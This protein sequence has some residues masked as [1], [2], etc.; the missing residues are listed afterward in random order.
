MLSRK[1][2]KDAHFMLDIGAV[3]KPP[4]T[5]MYHGRRTRIASLRFRVNRF[6]ETDLG[7]M[8]AVGVLSTCVFSGL[9]ISPAMYGIALS[10]DV[11]GAPG[12]P[13]NRN[14]SA[15]FHPDS[16]ERAYPVLSG[17]L[18]DHFRCSRTVARAELKW[19]ATSGDDPFAPRMGVSKMMVLPMLI[20]GLVGTVVIWVVTPMVLLFR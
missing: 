15:E 13:R 4:A 6:V 8:S 16:L 12:P 7:R 19:R 3:G 9:V 20:V 11:T 17:V 5:R 2:Q 18:R 14:R 10:S 1:A